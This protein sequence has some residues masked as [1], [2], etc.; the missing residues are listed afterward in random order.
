[1]AAA[2]AAAGGGLA[3]HV[4][5]EAVE[6]E[7]VVPSAAVEEVEVEVVTA[8]E[9]GVGG[10]A[11]VVVEEAAPTLAEGAAA[12]SGAGAAAGVSDL[13]QLAQGGGVGVAPTERPRSLVTPTA[14]TRNTRRL[15]PNVTVAGSS[16]RRTSRGEGATPH[17]S[18]ICC[19]CND[20]RSH[21]L[22]SRCV[23]RCSVSS[24][25]AILEYST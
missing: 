5:E 23:V 20:T 3:A 25:A 17:L 10:A 6:T 4:E 13:T 22:D 12:A 8:V 9:V 21:V 7:K 18:R 24:A 15:T 2:A 1:V 11:S 19:A 14:A 16:Q